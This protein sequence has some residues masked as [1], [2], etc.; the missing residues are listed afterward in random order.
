MQITLRMKAFAAVLFLSLAAHAGAVTIAGKTLA[1]KAEVGGQPLLLNG[2]G[3][4]SIF[5]FRVYIGALYL[6]RPLT[7][8]EAVLADTGPKRIELYIMRH[9]GADEFMDAFNKAINN[10]QTPQ[11][12]Q[13]ISARLA[14]FGRVFRAVG[15]VDEDTVILLDYL[16]QPGVTVLTINGRE[17]MRIPGADFYAA[18]LKIWL[19]SN[20]AQESLKK[21]MLG[22]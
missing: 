8:P 22:Q 14:Q 18:L 10:N 2:A 11:E 17:R 16:P 13:A 5:F 3:M 12:L 6:R 7:A 1:D 15:A 20:P 9:V 4:R 19:G 21:A